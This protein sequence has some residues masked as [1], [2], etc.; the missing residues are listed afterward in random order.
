MSKQLL[1]YQ[2]A[3]AVSAAR[4]RGISVRSG[5][6]FDFAREVN[7]V[8]LMAAEFAQSALEYAIVFVGEGD[9]VTPAVLLGVRDNENLFVNED[10]TW[11]GKYVPAFLRRYP[12]VFATDEGA[13]T[14]T[15]CIDEDFAGV[16]DE[17]RGERLFDEDGEQT[18]YLRSVLEFLQAYQVQ[19][20]RTRALTK[21]LVELDLLETM[22]ARFALRDGRNLTMSG[23]RVVSRD[24][25]RALS[26]EALSGL[27]QNDD[28]ELIYLHLHSLRYLSDT[29]ERLA[30][31]TGAEG[32]APAD[33]P[34]AP[35]VEAEPADL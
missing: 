2:R 10:G 26:G 20:V 24:R 1:I 6:N 7:S 11:G 23:L 8:P 18:Q 17:G 28:L 5:N 19:Y 12:F 29:A 35:A 30:V 32:E 4:H 31:L 22:Q 9:D 14:F 15:L 33:A 25:L 27:A 16:N 34:A 13:D 3:S 21:K